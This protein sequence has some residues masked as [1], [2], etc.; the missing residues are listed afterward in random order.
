MGL[1]EGVELSLW[2][3]RH[4][5]SLPPQVEWTPDL[6]AALEWADYVALDVSPARL[7]AP[8]DELGISAESLLATPTQVLVTIEMPCGF[9]GCFACYVPGRKGWKLACREGPVFDA[10]DLK[11]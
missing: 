6:S 10:G 5:P 3:E 1:A 9:G 2:T 11:W 4:P 7:R 8:L